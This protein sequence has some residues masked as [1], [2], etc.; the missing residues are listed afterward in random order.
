MDND[1]AHRRRIEFTGEGGAYFRIWIVNLLLS[2]V[3]LGIYSAWA[4]VRRLRYL[5]GNTLLDGSPFEFHGSPIALLKGRIVGVILLVAYSQSSKVSMGLWLA[6]VALLIVIFPWLIWKSLRF[7][8]AN[9]SY[10]GIRMGFTGSLGGSYRTFLPPLLFFAVFGAWGVTV[11]ASARAQQ[12]PSPSMMAG[13][14]I[15]MLLFFACAPWFWLRLKRYQH[16]HARLGSAPFSFTGTVGGAYGLAFAAIGMF[17][18]VAVLA[19]LVGIAGTVIFA[20]GGNRAVDPSTYFIIGMA[21]A[22]LFYLAVLSIQPIIRAMAQNFIW[23]KSALDGRAFK[24]SVRSGRFWLI[25]A[26]NFLATVLTLGL[27]WPFALIRTLRYELTCVEWCGDPAAIIAD[28]V[29]SGVGAAGEE[30]A[31]LL[32]FDLA[33]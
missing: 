8:L 1:D 6:V 19:I 23:N 33:L 31:D 5:Y 29:D 21:A 22:G 10:R 13:F 2:V 12:A 25:S 4:K 16:A 3:T 27:F 28:M 20:R 30:S 11:Q 18:G 9:T 15:L 7:R 17:L 24:S 32:G 26:G 14:G